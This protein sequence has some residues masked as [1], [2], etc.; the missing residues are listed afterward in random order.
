VIPVIKNMNYKR[1][2]ILN[3]LHLLNDLKYKEDY[4]YSYSRSKEKK[5]DSTIGSRI[6]FISAVLFLYND[7]EFS[8][9]TFRNF[10]KPILNI[11]FL[12]FQGNLI[13]VYKFVYEI[14]ITQ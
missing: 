14:L 5:L 9:K 3:L 13:D 1:F 2:F 7:L 12:K 10:N 6:Q 8:K 11:D 4:D